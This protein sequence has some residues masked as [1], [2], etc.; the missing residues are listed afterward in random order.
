MFWAISIILFVLWALG[1]ISG[2]PLGAWVHMLLLFSWVGLLLAVVRRSRPIR[3]E[4]RGR[5]S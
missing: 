1:L 3:R 4:L 2:A 5:R